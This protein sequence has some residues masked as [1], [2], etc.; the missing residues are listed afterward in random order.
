MR[1]R[2]QLS[3][4]CAPVSPRRPVLEF[5]QA[6]LEPLLDGLDQSRMLIYIRRHLIQNRIHLDALAHE[7]QIGKADLEDFVS[8]DR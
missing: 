6:L 2:M 8:H 1:I 4:T 5:L 7:F 3:H